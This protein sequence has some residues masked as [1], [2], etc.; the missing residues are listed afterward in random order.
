MTPSIG[1]TL[2]LFADLLPS[3]TLVPILTLLPNFGG[4][5]RTFQRVRLAS[6]GRL[7][8]RTPGP[9]PFGTCICSNVETILSWTCHVY[10]PFE[11]RTSLGT[12]IL[13]STR[14]ISIQ[15]AAGSSSSTKRKVQPPR[16]SEI[17]RYLCITLYHVIKQT[18][19]TKTMAADTSDSSPLRENEWQNIKLNGILW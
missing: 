8:L 18:T 6:G 3:W 13:P 2:H 7:L 10:G 14:W 15:L 12:S 17:R 5:H 9:V 19:P 16:K 11:F 1:R 4:F